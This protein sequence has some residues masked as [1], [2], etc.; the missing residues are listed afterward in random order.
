MACGNQFRFIKTIFWRYLKCGKNDR[1]NHERYEKSRKKTDSPLKRRERK[2][3]LW[4]KTKKNKKKKAK[5]IGRWF[6]RT[7]NAEDKT[8]I[9][10]EVK[11]KRKKEK[12]EKKRGGFHTETQRSPRKRNLKK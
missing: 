1:F 6:P 7:K 4:L 2:G 8:Q 5:D 11:D 12:Q 10:A 9:N 3:K